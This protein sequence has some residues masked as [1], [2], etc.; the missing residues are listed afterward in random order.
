M[1]SF[2][3][4]LKE[5]EQNESFR[6]AMHV[7]PSEVDMTHIDVAFYPQA[8]D[9]HDAMYT[10]EDKA[11]AETLQVDLA[12]A[13]WTMDNTGDTK[14]LLEIT[15]PK[16]SANGGFPR[17]PPFVRVVHPRFEFHTGHVTIGGSICTKMLT[18][19]GWE[20]TMSG[21][22]LLQAL[23]Q[24]FVLGKARVVLE[25]NEHHPHHDADYNDLEARNAFARV[26]AFHQ[27]N[28]WA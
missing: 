27:K 23:R 1:A 8:F 16:D 22:A 2:V 13:T 7:I 25:P 5:S 14:I 6:N 26:A 24:L 20:P 18:S 11:A 10:E 12:Q 3:K 17:E 4:Q 15:L 19:E 21:L 9:C 28:G